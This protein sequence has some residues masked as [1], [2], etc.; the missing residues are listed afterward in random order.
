[1]A[2]YLMLWE[3]NRDRIPADPKERAAGWT[4]L[5]NL[6]KE[7]L[8]SGITKSWGAFIGEMKGYC[9]V[10]GDEIEIAMMVQRYTPYVYFQ[11]LPCVTVELIG[12]MLE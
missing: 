2:R 4:T 1:M 11:T 3:L 9:L 5:T 12:Q 6:V 8:N 7:D 10:E